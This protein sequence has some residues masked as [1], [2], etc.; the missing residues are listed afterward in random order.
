MF[1]FVLIVAIAVSGDSGGDGGGH[2][3]RDGGGD[4]GCC[5]HHC[6]P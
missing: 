4:G 5:C 6:R 1:E 3:G 2:G